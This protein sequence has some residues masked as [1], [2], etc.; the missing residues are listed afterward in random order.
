MNEQRAQPEDASAGSIEQLPETQWSTAQK[1]VYIE[2]DGVFDELA[3]RR[4]KSLLEHVCHD[5]NEPEGRVGNMTV[6]AQSVLRE[7]G[8]E[9]QLMGILEAMISIGSAGWSSDLSLGLGVYC[10][11]RDRGRTHDQAVAAMLTTAPQ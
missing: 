6:R 3:I 4:M 7:R 10:E 11:L 1:L 9:Q 5:Y 8:I 2:T